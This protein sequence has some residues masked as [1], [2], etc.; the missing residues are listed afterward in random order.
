VTEETDI[1]RREP[2][3]RRHRGL[4]ETRRSGRAS[5]LAKLLAAAAILAGGLELG[6][7]VVARLHGV[8][9]TQ[10]AARERAAFVAHSAGEARATAS[11]EPR[12][13]HQRVVEMA[14]GARY[15]L[16]PY[17]GHTFWRGERG[18]NNHGFFA[19]FRYPYE[20]SGD[21][22]VVG[23]FGGSV[24]MQVAAGTALAEEL[25]PLAARLGRSR[26]TVLPFAIGGWREPQQFNA[27]VHY[28]ADVDVVIF[29]DGFNEIIQLAAGHL[30]SYPA[31]FPASDIFG[32]L[33]AAETSPYEARDRAL[34]SLVGGWMA[35]ATR[36]ADGPLLRHS[37]FVHEIWRL[38]AARYD[39]F[40]AS[41][42]ST[43][44]PASGSWSGIDVVRADADIARNRDRY[45]E[46]YRAVTA[47]AARLAR[48][49]GKPFFHFVQP[50]Q[51]LRGAKPLSEDERAHGVTPEWFDMVTEGYARLEEISGS[52]RGEGID[53]TFL[54]WVFRDERGTV[55]VDRCCHLNGRGL[56]RVVAAIVERVDASGR[57]GKVGASPRSRIESRIGRRKVASLHRSGGTVPRP[58][59]RPAAG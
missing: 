52:L 3:A 50:N 41:R 36:L 9:G 32:A 29:V 43:A 13:G 7:R 45:F 39:A 31:S 28:L 56:D 54:G 1:V 14:Y 57:L 58:L 26:V 34:L 17:F 6:A 2:L 49:A 51:H 23:V 19:T 25:A 42:R 55:Y 33:A 27:L 47:H 46:L 40:A 24:A 16:H 48:A 22:L 20:R 11:G 30:A 10:H 38:L 21:E 12:A 5:L 37:I 59:P 44:R 35:R 4:A 15:E 53:S 18:A 8:A